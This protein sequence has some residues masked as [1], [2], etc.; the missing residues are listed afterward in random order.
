M[1]H[2]MRLWLIAVAFAT[3]AA[4]VAMADGGTLRSAGAAPRSRS[5]I[6]EPAFAH[7]KSTGLLFV[8][9]FNN[10]V[11]DIYDL[12]NPK[13]PIGQIS[14]LL[15]LPQGLTVDKSG[16]LFVYDGRPNEIFEFEPPYTGL[17]EK[18]LF[19]MFGPVSGMTVDT[20]GTLYAAASYNQLFEFPQGRANGKGINL[21]VSPTGVT[22]DS[23][24]NL[25]CTYNNAGAAGV[26]KLTQ[27][28]PVPTN[29]LIPLEQSSADVLFDASGN[30][31]VEDLDGAYINIYPP[32]ST[33][34]SK[35][36]NDGFENPVHM[37]FNASKKLLVVSDFGN[38]TVKGIAYPSGGVRWQLSG[39][40]EVWGVAVSPAAVP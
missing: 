3:I 24:G 1:R 32:G 35:T 18:K 22:L 13:A 29:L 9:D 8:S 28:S 37:A 26:L 12:K 14:G 40:A 10:H 31:V 17:P 4:S 23:H 39:F 38:N 27:A 25:I 21:P 6:S 33:K 16:D 5:W 34:P 11:V 30:L 36:I 15:S 20:S 2:S 19:G 7:A